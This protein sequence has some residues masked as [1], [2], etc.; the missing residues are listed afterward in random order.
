MTIGGILG[1]GVSFPEEAGTT[2]VYAIGGSISA[3]GALEMDATRSI[4]GELVVFGGIGV[5]G[6]LSMFTGIGDFYATIGAAVYMG[7]QFLLWQT[8]Q[9]SWKRLGEVI[10]LLA[11]GDF[12]G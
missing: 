3:A 8:P 5:G 10:E 6:N 9:K 12:N 2:F 1:L 11:N 7:P 4:D